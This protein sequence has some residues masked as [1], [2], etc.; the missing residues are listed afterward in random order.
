[1]NDSDE[2]LP[3]AIIRSAIAWEM[4]LRQTGTDAQLHAPL[5]AW[6]NADPR[7]ELA[8]QRINGMAGLFHN[9][10]QHLPEPHQALH[11]LQRAETDLQRRRTLKLL[12]VLLV[13]GGSALTAGT[14]LRDWRGDYATTTGERR[15][16][17]LSS[18]ELQLNTATRVD[19]DGQ[20]L[21]LLEGEILL[22]GQQLAVSCRHAECRADAARFV[23]RQT[24]STT[25]HVARGSV[26]VSG[27]H[28]VRRVNAGEGL[29]ISAA[30]Y[31]PAAPSA[32]DPFAWTRG[33]L[34]VND[35][36][37]A[38]FLAEAGRYRRGWLGCDDAIAS[39]RLSGVFRL[40]AP[41]ALLANLSQL[42][43]IR[44][45]ERTRWWV[46]LKPVA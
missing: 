45:V 46:R 44:V 43:P 25:L 12:G 22:D 26:E 21:R 39:L 2:R 23:L 34:V 40:D 4:R 19:L 32:I 42:L 27:A 6:R 35:I 31:R 18:A 10:R 29:Q 16:V 36:R 24:G 11:A 33:L 14:Q 41:D 8:W 17:N 38:D 9:A 13:G 28:G 3:L 1:M 7:H 20:R 37:L 30:G 15:R 5:H